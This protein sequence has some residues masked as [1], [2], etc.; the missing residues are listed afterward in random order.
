MPLASV[1]SLNLPRSSQ[2]GGLV[3]RCATRAS[4]AVSYDARR[5]RKPSGLLAAAGPAAATPPAAAPPAAGAGQT[6]RAA[7]REA[8]HR[9][10]RQELHRVVMT[11]RAGAGRR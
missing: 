6:G 10:R 8:A 9:D 2:A 11:L 4:A 3:R 5:I 7:A 1:L